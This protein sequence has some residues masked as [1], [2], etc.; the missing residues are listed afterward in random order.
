MEHVA[1]LLLIVGCSGD[2]ERCAE[3]PAPTPI[4]ETYEECRANL[5]AS[6][7]GLRPEGERVFGTC[8][9]VD[10]ALEEA[11][12]QLYWDVRPDGTLEATIEHDA[13]SVM[14][15]ADTRTQ[16]VTQ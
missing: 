3:L 14:A 7:A 2:L 12:A 4:Y 5:D 15:N 9:Y 6:V 8:V 10:P 1:A 13:G 11:D 16:R